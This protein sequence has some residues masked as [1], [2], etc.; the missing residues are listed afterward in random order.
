MNHNEAYDVIKEHLQSL[1]NRQQIQLKT[2][3]K[4]N[5]GFKFD[6]VNL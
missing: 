4:S 1:L 6:F 5:G 2:S 3:T